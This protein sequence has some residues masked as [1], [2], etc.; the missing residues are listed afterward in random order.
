M[1]AV[2]QPTVP[3]TILTGLL[4]AALH[5]IIA[6]IRQCALLLPIL[7]VAEVVVAALP[8][9]EVEVFLVQEGNR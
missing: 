3:V 7:A 1:L 4:T 8:V 5:L 9:A 2:I 6:I